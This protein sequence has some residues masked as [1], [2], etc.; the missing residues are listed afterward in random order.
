MI[1]T[2]LAILSGFIIAVIS[3]L[4]YWGIVLLMAIYSSALGNN[5]S[6]FKLTHYPRWAM[7]WDLCKDVEIGNSGYDGV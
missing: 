6:V 4:G 2:I 1:E 7:D 5:A 3:S